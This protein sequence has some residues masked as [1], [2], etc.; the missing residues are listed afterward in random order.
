MRA[1]FR[2][3]RPIKDHFTRPVRIAHPTLAP[4][5]PLSPA[6]LGYRLA[7][8]LRRLLPIAMFLL[9]RDGT[10]LNGHDLFLKRV[11]AAYHTF[12]EDT[13]RSCLETCQV[14]LMCGVFCGVRDHT[15][16]RLKC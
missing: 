12:V 15:I 4:A 8:I 7:H 6:Q 3:F 16:S 14:C 11:G 5:S 2:P 10:F 13:Q 1:P 9:Q